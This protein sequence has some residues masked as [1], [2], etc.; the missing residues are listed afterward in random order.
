MERERVAEVTGGG[1]LFASLLAHA[2]A[3]TGIDQ[4]T[5]LP[6]QCWRSAS[7]V[8]KRRKPQTRMALKSANA[9]ITRY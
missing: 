6:R 4:I 7:H 9:S 3:V 1:S 2:N 5:V 8:A